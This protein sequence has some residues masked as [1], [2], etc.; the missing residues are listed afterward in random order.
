M[1][2]KEKEKSRYE[3]HKSVPKRFADNELEFVKRQVQSILDQQNVKLPAFKKG[4][5]LLPVV[6]YQAYSISKH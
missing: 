3:R 6:N 2:E 4:N 5:T 1:R